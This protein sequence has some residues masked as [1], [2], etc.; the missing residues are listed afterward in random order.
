MIESLGIGV[1]KINIGAKNQHLVGHGMSPYL[2]KL[3]GMV[4]QHRLGCAM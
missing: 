2:E 3:E 4:V 1:V